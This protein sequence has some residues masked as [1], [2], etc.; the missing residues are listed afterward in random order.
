MKIKIISLTEDKLTFLLEG[1]GTAFANT[2]R[3]TMLSE[4]PIMAIEDIFYFDNTSLVPDEVLA[5]RIGLVP[6]N[7][8]LENY[9]LPEDCDCESDL[10]CPRCRVILTID[11]QSDNNDSI[12][13]YSG[14]L[15]SEDPDIYPVSKKI[16]LAKLAPN[17][18]IRLEAYAQLGK[19]KDHAKWS[20]V[21]M[22]IYQNV[23]LVPIDDTE[24]A[25]EC[26]KQCGI[27]V[28]EIVNGY[29]KVINIIKFESFKLCRD[30][31]SHEDIMKNLKKNEFFFTIE[32]NGALSPEAILKEAIKILKKKLL[33]LEEKIDK[34]ELHDE[35]SDFGIPEFEE[36]TLYT[37]GSGNLENDEKDEEE[38]VEGDSK[39]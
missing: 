1:V 7:T 8:S 9:V 34:N 14:E 12:T 39:E 20:P 6:L 5:H 38:F 17:Q 36:G 11:V 16:P 26:L 25:K 3:R 24:S 10:G 21:S 23:S 18:S 15:E 37:V 19:G 28:A 22:C 31:V 27:E 35:I 13:V 4:V 2:L 32:S 29:I 33:K 30:I